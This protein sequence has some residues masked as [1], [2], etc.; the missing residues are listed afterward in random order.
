MDMKKSWKNWLVG[1]MLGGLSLTTVGCATHTQEGALIGAGSGALLGAGI[2]SLSHARSGEGALIGAAVGGLAG[3]L[4]GNEQDRQEA[5]G[6]S[7]RYADRYYD[8]PP[9]VYGYYEY[10]RPV[11]VYE[12]R[13]YVAPR[14]CG[15]YGYRRGWYRY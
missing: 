4:I 1:L 8:A 15:Y 2:G 13:V 10:D 3:G 14:P 6:Y 5:Y 11:R 7:D 12:R 9:P